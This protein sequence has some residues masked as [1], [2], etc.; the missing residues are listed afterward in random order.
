MAEKQKKNGLNA[1]DNSVVIGGSVQGSN[2]VIGNKNTVS[3]S[4]VNIA[5]LFDEIYKKLDVKKD[6]KPQEKED[7]YADLKEVQ[8]ELEKPEP[9]ETFLARRFRN[10][11]RMAPDIADIALETLKNPIS[12]VVE[13]IKKVT[14]KMGEDAK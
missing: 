12:G 10:I 5:P 1:G 9:N 7:V 2:I 13:V 4:S 14:K 11:K 8:K 3:N 6:L